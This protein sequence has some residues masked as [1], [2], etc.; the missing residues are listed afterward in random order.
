[1]STR[2]LVG[3]LAVSCIAP[4]AS[5]SVSY[6]AWW[7]AG[8]PVQDGRLAIHD[9]VVRLRVTDTA[10]GI[11]YGS[12]VYVGGAIL[13]DGHTTNYGGG[14]VASSIEIRSGWDVVNDPW[15][16]VTTTSYLTHPNYNPDA[17]VGQST[18][19]SIIYASM[20]L[21]AATWATTAPVLGATFRMSGFGFPYTADGGQQSPA[22]NSLKLAGSNVYQY[23][24]ESFGYNGFLLCQFQEDFLGLPDEWGATFGDSGGAWWEM[25]NGHPELVALTTFT[26]GFTYGSFTGG[27]S[28]ARESAWI[29]ANV[30]APASAV[31][32][33]LGLVTSRRRRAYTGETLVR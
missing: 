30:P 8:H 32:L 22:D 19:L 12:G 24:G 14:V 23:R 20:A 9:P 5:G 29:S 21:P 2:A 7:A 31:F 13:C 6:D 16:V 1:M 18:D 3:L 28:L 10:G 4:F 25:R 11:H 17:G 33:A 27:L 26:S 15:Q